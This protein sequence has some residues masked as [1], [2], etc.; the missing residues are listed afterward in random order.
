MWLNSGAEDLSLNGTRCINWCQKKRH[1][2]FYYYHEWNDVT[3]LLTCL[4]CTS[5]LFLESDLPIPFMNHFQSTIVI[6][7]YYPRPFSSPLS[8]VFSFYF[9][10]TVIFRFILDLL[11]RLTRR[12]ASF[13]KLETDKIRMYMY[14]LF[15][16][17]SQLQ[18]FIQKFFSFRRKFKSKKV[19]FLSEYWLQSFNLPFK[20]WNCIGTTNQIWL[21]KKKFTTKESSNTGN[22][23]KPFFIIWILYTRSM[24]KCYHYS[25]IL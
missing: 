20:W 11:K 4:P 13:L 14:S 16:S 7:N 3:T 10:L 8:F 21:L 2:Y 1:F 25:L 12:D 24:C 6:T 22:D 23:G 15:L 19:Q 5:D 18:V 17:Y 9:I